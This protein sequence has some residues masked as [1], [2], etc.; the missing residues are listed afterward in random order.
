MKQPRFA[1]FGTADNS[2]EYGLVTDDGVI[3]LSRRVGDRWPTL[4]AAI[5]DNALDTLARDY[6]HVP[7]DY[8]LSEITWRLPITDPGKIICVGVNYP[9]RNAEYQDGQAA[10]EYPS[11]F[12]RV[13][14]SLTGHLQPLVRPPESEQLDYEGEVAIIIGKSGR[15][16]PQAHAIDHIA[17]VTLC[18]DGT[19][20]DWV[21]H[22][23]FNVTQGKNFHHSGSM[24]PWLVPVTDAAQ[25]A[26]IRLTT[27]VNG[28]LRQDDRTS[29]MCF[30]F[31]HIIAY[32]STFTH[33]DAGDIIITGTPSGA[34]ARFTPPVWLKPGD[35]VDVAAE[36]L[37]I[38]RNTVADEE[39]PC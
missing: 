13:P 34:G 18:N 4:K 33:L 9:D 5:A 38:L 23:K 20:R 10:P 28:E 2:L 24:G 27:H 37:G 17:A 22:A 25:L 26:D 1:T 7:A 30:S 39:Q 36:G 35:V 12:M 3:S 8:R 29:R 31:A 16:I 15:R 19:L 14:D 11:L 6:A 32:I 21:R